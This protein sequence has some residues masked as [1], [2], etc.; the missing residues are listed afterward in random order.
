MGQLIMT[1]GLPGSGKS[2][3]AKDQIKNRKNVKRVNKDDLRA[4]LDC[5][6]WSPDNEKFVLLTRDHIINEAMAKG[7]DVIV[8]DTN[9]NPKMR[10]QLQ[11]IVDVSNNVRAD[12]YELVVQ[13]EFLSVSPEDC[14]DRDSHRGP[15]SYVGPEVIDKMCAD[16]ERW[17]GVKL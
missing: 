10:R 1:M 8:D 7:Y 14:K 9:L 15:G 3:W 12:R 13:D 6:I 5:G 17:Y 4:M 2:T 16:Y 11:Q